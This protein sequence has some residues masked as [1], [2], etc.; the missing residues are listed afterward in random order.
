MGKCQG[1]ARCE[2]QERR[3]TEGGKSKDPG[4]G[5]AKKHKADDKLKLELSNKLPKLLSLSTTF[6][7]M[8]PMNCFSKAFQEAADEQEN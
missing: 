8:K 6:C 2:V 4:S 7:K 1:R 5:P 3:D